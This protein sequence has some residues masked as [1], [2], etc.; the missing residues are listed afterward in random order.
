MKQELFI[1]DQRVD[2]P[3]NKDIAFMFKSNLLNA[4]ITAIMQSGSY[5]IE[6]PKTLRNAKVLDLADMVSYDSTFPYRNHKAVFYRNGIKIFEGVSLLLGTTNAYRIQLIWSELKELA[7]LLNQELNLNEYLDDNTFVEWSANSPL[8]PFQASMPNYGFFHYLRFPK[9][10]SSAETKY[11]LS[12]IHPSVTA[13]HILQ[14]IQQKSGLEFVFRTQTENWLKK[15]AVLCNQRNFSN[16][17]FGSLEPI[18]LG[19]G[20]NSISL[21]Q[22]EIKPNVIIKDNIIRIKPPYSKFILMMTATWTQ[23]QGLNNSLY[24]TL[25]KIDGA[26]LASFNGVAADTNNVSISSEIMISDESEFYFTATHTLPTFYWISMIPLEIATADFKRDI[27][28]P[29]KFFPVYFNLP[30]IKITEF[31]RNI[32]HLTGNFVTRNPSDPTNRITFVPISEIYDKK[33]IGLDWS[34]KLT[35]EMESERKFL[36]AQRNT[37]QYAQDDDVPTRAAADIIVDDTTIPQQADLATM[38]FSASETVSQGISRIVQ[39][40]YVPAE[41]D[42]NNVITTPES[43]NYTEVKPRINSIFSTSPVKLLSFGGMGFET[44]LPQFYPEYQNLVKRPIK[45][46]ETFRLNELD[47]KNIDYT[48]PI[49]LRQYGRF[50]GIIQITEKAGIGKAELLQLTIS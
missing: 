49:Y 13:W 14:K 25:R 23:A 21:T 16:Y 45:I 17:N 39:Y 18:I 36:P 42:E 29:T 11:N 37:M 20:Q 3:A 50:Y 40:E 44:L 38:A 7:A 15:T 24:L 1:N 4:D 46:I 33:A 34:R 35:G 32:C 8:I 19:G 10:Q 2:L 43:V 27:E 48:V 28:Y 5:A 9:E 31:I 6:L 41:K 22:G 12:Q 30:K 26:I 47:L